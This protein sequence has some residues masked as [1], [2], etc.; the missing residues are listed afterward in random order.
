MLFI[1]NRCH[2]AKIMGGEF[3][4]AKQ[5]CQP[6]HKSSLLMLSARLSKY[7]GHKIYFTV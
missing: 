3:K 2:Q 5:L 6:K 1:E 4:A 7:S